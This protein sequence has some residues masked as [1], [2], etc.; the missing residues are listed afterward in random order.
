MEQELTKNDI[1][2]IYN[3]FKKL[4]YEDLDKLRNSFIVD[5]DKLSD[6]GETDVY[7]Y[8]LSDKMNEVMK[9][10]SKLKLKELVRKMMKE[11]FD[12]RDNLTDIE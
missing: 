11:M 3:D 7:Q 4:P 10:D 2:I 1:R 9:P 5:E 6:I 12:G 8:Y